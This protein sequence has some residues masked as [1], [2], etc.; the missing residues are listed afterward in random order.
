MDLKYSTAEEAVKVIK[1]NQRVFVHGSAATPTSLLK[2]LAARKGELENVEIVSITTLGDMPLA[3]PSC[4][5]SFLSTPCLFP[6][7]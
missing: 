7:M 2:A 3:D 1:S 6:K 4:K 5:G